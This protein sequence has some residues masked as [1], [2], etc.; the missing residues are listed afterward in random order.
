MLLQDKLVICNMIYKSIIFF[1][2]LFAFFET[3]SQQFGES[4]ER[5]KM[6]RKSARH[7]KNKEAFNPYL[8]KKT[9][10]S[11]E[12]GKQSAREQKRQLKE[13]RKQK[14]RNMKKLGL[15]PTKVKKA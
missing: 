11:Q 1:V 3:Y 13:A 6:W 7:R 10:P 12:L 2:L 5:K 8:D 15:K 4:R 9:K 14:R